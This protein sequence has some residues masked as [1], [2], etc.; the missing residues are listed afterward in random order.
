VFSWTDELPNLDL[1][2]ANSKGKGI[3]KA[4]R[5]RRRESKVEKRSEQSKK[6]VQQDSHSISLWQFE[7]AVE[8][9]RLNSTF[10]QLKLHEMFGRALYK[11]MQPQKGICTPLAFEQMQS[12]HLMSWMLC[13]G[14]DRLK[15]LLAR[16]YD[17]QKEE[18]VDI[19]VHSI[20]AFHSRQEVQVT[21]GA[22]SKY[23]TW[24]GSFSG[25]VIKARF[26]N[27]LAHEHIF[28]QT[29]SSE[30]SAYLS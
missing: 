26:G 25:K 4:N 5:R 16:T 28:F 8:L 21:M 13:L 1:H 18:I 23:S 14:E 29:Y 9:S 12:E 2:P 30:V 27:V 11:E 24:A 15:E 22:N 7:T 3:A 10:E 6:E 17:S 19:M 20:L